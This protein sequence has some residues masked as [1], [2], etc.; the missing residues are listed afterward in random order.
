MDLDTSD[1][2][3]FCFSI[4]NS[5]YIPAEITVE[6]FL[7]NVQRKVIRRKITGTRLGVF[8]TNCLVTAADD[9]ENPD[10]AALMEQLGIPTDTHFAI[11]F[12]SNL[13]VI[14]SH[15]KHQPAYRSSII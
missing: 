5:T 2:E 8:R 12:I 10:M 6:I 3:D 15:K 1:P 7:E 13:P 9:P 4:L 14:I 11:R